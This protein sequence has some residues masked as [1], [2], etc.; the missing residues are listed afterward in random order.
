M[1]VI[2]FASMFFD[3]ARKKN[4]NCVYACLTYRY[5]NLHSFMRGGV[6]AIDIFMI[7]VPYVIF[8]SKKIFLSV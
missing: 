4:C 1:F 2:I 3:V 7:P 6:N 8:F 5:S